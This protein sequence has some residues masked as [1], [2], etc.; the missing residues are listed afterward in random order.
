MSSKKQMSAKLPFC[1][2]CF[3]AGKTEKEY[4]SHYVRSEP[5]PNSKVVCPTLLSQCCGFCGECGHTP[6]FCR[7]LTARK[8]AEEKASKQ[9]AHREALEKSGAEK[10]AVPAIKKTGFAAAF[11]SDSE[12]ETEENVSKKVTY[13]KVQAPK[14]VPSPKP[15]T[16]ATKPK[17]TRIIDEFPALKSATQQPT[18]PASS[19]A[20]T[21]KPAFMSAINQAYPD[22]VVGKTMPEVN[23][24][25][26][27]VAKLVRKKT[28][29]VVEEYPEPEPSV[30]QGRVSLKQLMLMC[31]D[32]P[33]DFTPADF[34]DAAYAYQRPKELASNLNWAMEE[35]ESDDD[36]HLYEDDDEDW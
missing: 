2:V 19:A 31:P 16:A 30:L 23:T 15:V 28:E 25:R 27:P 10:K 14:Q 1:K 35:S 11:G 3:D 8:A 24:Y 17:T 13:K 12:S 9:S 7:V 6:K 18:K 33:S 20:S 26:P 29:E 36:E 21:Q 34:I 4:T 22:L 32:E 5:G